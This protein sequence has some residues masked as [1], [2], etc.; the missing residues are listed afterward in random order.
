MT[1]NPYKHEDFFAINNLLVSNSQTSNILILQK[2]RRN[3][4][5]KGNQK[6]GNNTIRITLKN[7][8]TSILAIFPKFN[9]KTTFHPWENKS[10]F[11]KRTDVSPLALSKNLASVSNLVLLQFLHFG[12]VCV[13][14]RIR[15]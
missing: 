9:R 4:I 8:R 12:F 10:E 3:K 11:Y 1:V 2:E 7:N 14:T 13:S 15:V 5:K 6:N